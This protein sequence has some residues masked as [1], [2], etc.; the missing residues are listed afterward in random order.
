LMA[1]VCIGGGCVGGGGGGD[2]SNGVVCGVGG[3]ERGGDGCGALDGEGDGVISGRGG[4]D[5]GGVSG[6]AVG[7]G[8]GGGFQDGI[9]KPATSLPNICACGRCA[10]SFATIGGG[11]GNTGRCERRCLHRSMSIRGRGH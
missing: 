4:G 11:I 9:L 2:G 6:V 3:G 8:V 5:C 1:L 10:F 7:G